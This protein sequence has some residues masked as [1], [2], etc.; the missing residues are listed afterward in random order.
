MKYLIYVLIAA[1][2]F[3]S[4]SVAQKTS[5][6]NEEI[7][8]P[9]VDKTFEQ[10]DQ[11]VFEGEARRHDERT[12]GSYIEYTRA[13][14]GFGRVEYPHNAYFKL[15]K[16][17]YP[18]GNVRQK[19]VM[20]ND[21]AKYGVWYYFD[22]EEQLTKQENT[23]EGYKYGW[24]QLIEDCKEKKIPLMKGKPTSGGIKTEIHKEVLEGK[25]VW[26]ISYLDQK[27]NK[28]LE[29]ILSGLNGEEV[30]RRE[31]EFVGN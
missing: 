9:E 19:G 11:T 15:I 16:S 5:E 6:M 18:N 26:R 4:C 20:F 23:D 29:V 24:I 8:I 7:M 25:R 2:N 13:N 3:T 21:G 28:Y 17:F 14:I 1:F 31:L 12:K 30:S 27:T 22:E 10:F